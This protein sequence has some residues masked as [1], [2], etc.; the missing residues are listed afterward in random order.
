MRIELLDL[1]KAD[2]LEGFHFYEKNEAGLG[3]YYLTNLFSDIERLKMS[4]GWKGKP[5]N[6]ANQLV[7]ERKR[8]GVKSCWEMVCIWTKKTETV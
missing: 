4:G 2:L 5:G 3:D 7:T 6:G 1:A 8:S